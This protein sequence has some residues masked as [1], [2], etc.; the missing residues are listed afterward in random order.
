MVLLMLVTVG[1]GDSSGREQGASS[2][3]C[4]FHDEIGGY[5]WQ[6]VWRMIYL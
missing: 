6:K 3:N 5:I 2:E 1:L 4:R